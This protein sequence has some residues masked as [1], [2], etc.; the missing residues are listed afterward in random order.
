MRY[1]FLLFAL[2]TCL[3]QA[4]TKPSVI[5][6]QDVTLIDANHRSGLAHQTIVVSG[7]KILQ[8]FK[9]GASP[10]PDSCTVINL[11]GKYIIPGLV[12]THVH[13]ATDPSGVDNRTATLDVL[14]RMLYSGITSVRDMAGDARTLAGLARD[15]GTGD[16]LAPDIYYSALM[17]GPSFFL[18]SRRNTSYRKTRK[19]KNRCSAAWHS[20]PPS[21][22]L[23]RPMALKYRL[24]HRY[25][26]TLPPA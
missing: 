23:K 11:A 24:R 14:Q 15:A 26:R 16:I 20:M 19:P 12:D 10:V 6:L 18:I 4:Q 17:A 9:A 3:V 21:W 25:L 22:N 8:V 5:V 1:F 2:S 13:L 7:K